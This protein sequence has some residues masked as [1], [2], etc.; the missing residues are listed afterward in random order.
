MIARAVAAS[1][2]CL[3][4]TATAAPAAGLLGRIVTF[5]GVVYDDPAH[6]L[7]DGHGATVVVGEGVEFGLGPEGAQNAL[8]IVP[9]TVNIGADRIDMSYEHAG[10]GHFVEAGFNGYELRFVTSCA[11]IED[12]VIDAGTTTLPLDAIELRHSATTL[13]LDVAGQAYDPTTRIGMTLD[14]ADCPLS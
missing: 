13:W 12:A 11:L 10:A 6:P 2:L 3:G 4:A 5:R 8:D 9:V 14:V 1:L 7:F